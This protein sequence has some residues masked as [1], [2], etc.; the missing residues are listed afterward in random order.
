[1]NTLFPRIRYLAVLLLAFVVCSSR[2]KLPSAYAEEPAAQASAPAPAEGAQQFATLG[3]FKLQSGIILRGFRLGYRTLGKLDAN[4]TNAILWPSWLGGTTQ[5]LLEY[6]GPGKVVDST[7]YFVILVDS[8]GNGVSTSPSNSSSHPG[9]KFPQIT[10]HDMVESEHRLATEVFKLMHLRAV[11]G[12]SM[13]GMQTFAW[14]LAYPDFLDL[15]IPMEGSPQSTSYD[16]LLWTSEIDALKLDPAW[17]NG[18]PSGPL[19]RGAALA[20]QIDSMNLTSPAYRVTHTAPGAF[21]AFVTDIRKNAAAAP[22]AALDGVRQRQAIIAL[23]MPRE[24]GAS[25]AEL[26]KRV[27]AKVLVI[28]PAQDHMVNPIPALQFAAAISAPVITLDSP[29]GHLS[30]TCISVGPIVAQFLANP[31]SVTSQTLKDPSPH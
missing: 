27:H 6:I 20:D 24:Y 31:A 22:S 15:A 16:A 4:K 13:G 10:I 12:I 3:D 25:L 5:E 30:L 18:N 28:A 26:A 23:D 14:T 29:C 21:P 17:N 11:M 9:S 19:T 2:A 8:I 7:K 1:V